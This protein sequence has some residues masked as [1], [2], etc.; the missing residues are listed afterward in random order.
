MTE[1]PFDR[2]TKEKK[3]E[4]FDDMLKM[5]ACRSAIKAGDFLEME[6]MKRLVHELAKNDFLTCPHGR[7][8]FIKMTTLEL[9]K[10]FKRK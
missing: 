8:I 1:L 2:G 3:E 10:K 7:P 5:F 4:L 9:E 6:E